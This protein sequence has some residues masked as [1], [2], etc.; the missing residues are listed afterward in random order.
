QQFDA[1][2]P[3]VYLTYLDFNNLYGWAM[4]QYLPMSHFKW[5]D[6][7]EYDSIDWKTI[8]TKSNIG[9]ILEVDLDYPSNLHDKHKNFPLAPEKMKI[10]NE[11]LSDYQLTT[12]QS[13]KQ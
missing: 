9:Y 2:K 7:N 10:P 6:Q 3:T 4:N 13:L 12:I 11:M 8:N 1:S 5:I